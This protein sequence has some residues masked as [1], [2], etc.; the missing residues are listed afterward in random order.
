MNID[1]KVEYCGIVASYS[2]SL[3]NNA[4]ARPNNP[5]PVTRRAKTV[6]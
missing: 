2:R 3:E 6:I 1:S 5:K 4:T